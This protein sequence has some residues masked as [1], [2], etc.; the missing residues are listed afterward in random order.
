ALLREKLYP[1][2][3]INNPVDVL[4]TAGPEHFAAA[5]Q[6][7]MDELN[8]DAV[9]LNFVTPFFVDT[10]GVAR[11]IAAANSRSRKPIVA[12]VMTE[13]KGWAETL[14]VIRDSGVPTYDMPE[15]GAR[16]LASMGRYAALAARPVETFVPFSGVDTARA[17]AILRAA[18]SNG[19]T[20]LPADAA[21]ELLDCYGIRTARCS[22]AS[23]VEECVTAA[24][25]IGYPVVLK[26]EA[27]GVIHKTE[28]GGVVLD[29]RDGDMLAAQ[30]R[31]MAER[32]ADCA[33]KFLVQEHL[34]SGREVIVGANAV[35]GLGH[36]VMFGLGGIFV[37]VLK[38]VS[39]EI[40]PVTESEA[41][42][43]IESVRT[44]RLL[45]GLRGQPGV[46][47]PALSECIR[48]TSQM[49]T[50]HPEIRELDIN[51]LVAYE[52]GLIAADVRVML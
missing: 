8:I 51:P 46:D 40:A 24:D 13:K 3:S 32:F 10:L 21:F 14:K 4:A 1:E 39:F 19:L 25:R 9:F 34:A 22:M 45:E 35:E 44:C 42:R 15:T 33:P 50:S 41:Q 27:P 43:M 47:L 38:D 11:E 7:L 12:T 16:V 48:R 31:Q 2:A 30:A 49:V 28:R 6:A 29:L 52:R 23:N 20:L 37:E 5:M 18:A 17:G 36:V 26:V